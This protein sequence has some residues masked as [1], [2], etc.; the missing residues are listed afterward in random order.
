MPDQ[1]PPQVWLE[2]IDRSRRQFS[3]WRETARKIVARY[4]REK[5]RASED[6]GRSPDGQFNV[7]F[8]NVQTMRPALYSRVPTV[9]AERRH[10]DKDPV[11]RVAAEVIARA[12]NSEVEMN[13]LDDALTATVLD[14]LLVGRG[15]PWVRFEA[16]EQPPAA[17][18][19]TTDPLTGAE[20]LMDEDGVPVEE[21]DV[22]TG[23]DG[24]RTVMRP[25]VNERTVVDYVHWSDF[26]HAAERSWADLAR[27]GWVARRVAMSKREG[28]AKFGDKFNRVE[29]TMTRRSGEMNDGDDDGF[30]KSGD[31]DARYAEV[32]EI[33][34]KAT[35]RRL[36]VAKGAPD[37][38][39][40]EEDPYQ[41]VDFFPCPRPAY[42]VLTNE[43]LVP[44]PDYTQYEDLAVE[45]SR[46]SARINKL[47]AGLKLVGIYDAS[48]EGLGN[49][50]EADDNTMVAVDNMM[51]VEG[52]PGGLNSA[53]QYLPV[54]DVAEV[55]IQLYDA[56]DRAKQ[57]LYEISGVSDIVRGQVDPREKASQSQLKSQWA[58]ARLD[59]RRRAAERCAR[60]TL[61]IM[62]EMMV[63]LYSPERLREQSGFDQINELAEFEQLQRDELWA[64]VVGLLRDGG[65]RDLRIDVE[66]DSTIEMDAG[67]TKEDRNEFL[68][69]AGGFLQ[70][71]APLAQTMPSLAPVIGEMLLY[72]VR[73]YRAGRQIESA[74]EQAIEGVKQQVEQQQQQAAAEAQ[75]QQAMEQQA[76]EQQQ[77]PPD[78]RVDAE[79]ARTQQQTQ[80][81]AAKAQADIQKTQAQT[82][83][84]VARAQQQA[85]MS[86]M[87]VVQ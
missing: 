64:Q 16:D 25:P 56:R 55:L 39:S 78:P 28:K 57:A 1:V 79:A 49:L 14:V 50:L 11:G 12:A 60:D 4:R 26:T 48:M 77:P 87:G 45:L 35:R 54:R 71:V 9:A 5:N 75:Q 68:T 44:T 22:E 62:V 69:A 61:R 83:A 27:E 70:N 85:Q 86:Q 81:D 34:D 23:K 51:N 37:Y 66:S 67:Q 43:D 18:T 10:K 30:G 3:K 47:V 52:R 21:S 59:Q 7:L 32:W 42:G 74:F 13:G 72:T 29:L 36:H 8:S 65:V 33:W 58:S 6:T 80:L 19:A 24:E 38:L 46:L 63:E 73:G 20:T 76:Q 31:E 84:T 41:L 82:A 40:N 53:V 15:V 2:R 17:V